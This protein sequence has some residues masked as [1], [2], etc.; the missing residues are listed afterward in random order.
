MTGDI[1]IILYFLFSVMNLTTILKIF[2]QK[3]T[4]I[5]SSKAYNI[6]FDEK[7]LWMVTI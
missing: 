7:F 4:E 1:P 3:S 6:L 5:H 2:D